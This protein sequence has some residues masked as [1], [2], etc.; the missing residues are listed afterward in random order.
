MA[1]QYNNPTSVTG[2]N[3]QF[4][5]SSQFNIPSFVKPFDFQQQKEEMQGYLDRYSKAIPGIRANVE[6]GLGIPQ[7]REAF[8][9]ATQGAQNYQDLINSLPKTIA[10]TSA[11]SLLNEGQRQR[12]LGEKLVPLQKGLSTVQG[13]MSTLGTAL[14]QAQTSAEKMVTE[15]LDPYAKDFDQLTRRLAQEFTGWTTA[16]QMELNRLIQNAQSGLTWTNS[17]AQ[18][19]NELAL[20]EMKYKETMDRIRLEGQNQIALKRT[21]PSI[22]DF[23]ASVARG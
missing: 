12:L 22:G 11:N 23:I 8:L 4:G 1:T 7:M 16:N 5:T 10:E 15:R 13:T 17:E 18:R 2:I 3:P 21:S 6:S 9:G 19:A 20:Q 14:G